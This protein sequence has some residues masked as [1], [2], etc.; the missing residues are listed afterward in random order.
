MAEI[1]LNPDPLST[2][3][4]QAAADYLAAL[5]A[6]GVHPEGFAWAIDATGQFH[7]LMVTSLVDR[8][9]PQ[10]VYDT[11][12]K[13]YDRAVTPKAIDPWIVSAFSPKSGF[14]KAY[15]E[16][17]DIQIGFHT[18]DGQDLSEEFAF[19]TQSIGPFRI[20]GNWMYIKG[21]PVSNPEAQLRGWHRFTKD[22]EKLAA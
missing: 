5:R 19:V 18:E 17:I 10:V 6:H 3:R 11:L 1:S 14:G 4:R 9:G 2:E 16:I 8:V 15:L 20:R 13:A 12:F 7:L 21:K 22:I